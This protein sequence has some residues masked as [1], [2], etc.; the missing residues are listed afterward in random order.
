MCN[1]IAIA[2]KAQKFKGKRVKD[3]VWLTHGTAR[4]P[5]FFPASQPPPPHCFPCTLHSPSLPLSGLLLWSSPAWKHFPAPLVWQRRAKPDGS[6]RSKCVADK[7]VARSLQQCCNL[8][9]YFVFSLPVICPQLKTYSEQAQKQ[10]KQQ[11]EVLQSPRSLE[12]ALDAGF[13]FRTVNSTSKVPTQHQNGNN[14]GM[15][16]GQP[17]DSISTTIVL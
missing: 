2:S 4:L 15:A 6:M 12:Q 3:Q 17:R 16:V 1:H 13:C 10:E 8:H 7:S 14:M 5:S 9:R 11:S